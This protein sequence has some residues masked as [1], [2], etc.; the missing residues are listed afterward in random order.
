MSASE[1]DESYIAP[2]CTSSLTAHTGRPVAYVPHLPHSLSTR[3]SCNHTVF[4]SSPLFFCDY[5]ILPPPEKL[6]RQFIHQ[7]L[8]G[9]PTNKL[10][11]S[12]Q[13]HNDLIPQF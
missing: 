13:K 6:W 3:L 5:L 7:Q 12:R 11:N 10:S 2:G 8:Q 9:T 1:P 4:A